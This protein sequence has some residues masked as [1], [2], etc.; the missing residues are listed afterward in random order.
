[1]LPVV[2]FHPS[3]WSH[4]ILTTLTP[5][6]TVLD[7]A[8]LM[9]DLGDGNASSTWLGQSGPQSQ[10]GGRWQRRRHNLDGRSFF[11]SFSERDVASLV[12]LKGE[13]TTSA[14]G[15]L[16][17]IE[18]GATGVVQISLSESSIDTSDGYAGS[19]SAVGANIT[20]YGTGDGRSEQAGLSKEKQASKEE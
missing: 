1:M 8:D 5:W 4:Q 10:S 7:Q 18:F 11:Q 15:C 17:H 3:Q 20:T 12:E 14:F 13:N 2:T 19:L 6:M 9:P 16:I